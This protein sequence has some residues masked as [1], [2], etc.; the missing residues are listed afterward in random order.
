MLPYLVVRAGGLADRRFRSVVRAGSAAVFRLSR[1][2]LSTHR[3]G[4]NKGGS[5][6]SQKISQDR[7]R[8]RRRSR[9]GAVRCACSA[10]LT[11]RFAHFARR[12]SPGQHRRQAVCEPRRSAHQRRDQDQHL[13]QQ[14]ARRPAGA[15]AADQAR[16]HR[17]GV[18][19]AGPA[20]QVRHG[21]R[22]GDAAVHLGQLGAG[23][24]RARRA[25]HG[26]GSR[27]WPKSRASSCCATGNTASAT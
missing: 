11:M 22:G 9:C 24:P 15:G 14:R 4:V 27:R 25:G 23:L 3:D 20:R 2:G 13:S 1:V 17:H 6:G 26:R 19:D 12:R 21:F 5:H 8:G 16:H 7:R 10:P 18:A